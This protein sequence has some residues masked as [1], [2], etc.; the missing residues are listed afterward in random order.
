MQSYS[1]LALLALREKEFFVVGT[2]LCSAEWLVAFLAL[3]SLDASS[4]LFPVGKPKMSP[5]KVEDTL[6]DKNHP[7]KN[8]L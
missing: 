5:E 7:V 3:H 1:T 8:H 6:G 4:T 2:G